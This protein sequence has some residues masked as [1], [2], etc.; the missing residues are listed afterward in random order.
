MITLNLSNAAS[1]SP[2]KG[3]ELTEA[4]I[5]N[6]W[7]LWSG[8]LMPKLHDEATPEDSGALKRA[9]TAEIR[10]DK[11]V[12]AFQRGAFYW[13]FLPEMRAEYNRI[14]EAEIPRMIEVAYQQAQREVGMKNGSK[15]AS[16]PR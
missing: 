5:R 10:G 15:S 16:L 3:E 6:F 14:Y 8:Y 9:L 11:F 13:R 1:L 2:E 7:V 4:F 12:I